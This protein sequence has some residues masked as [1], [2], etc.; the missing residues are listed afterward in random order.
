[1]PDSIKKA[2]VGSGGAIILAATLV[3]SGI[4]G[5]NAVDT[6]GSSLSPA[7][8]QALKAAGDTL[9]IQALSWW[10]SCSNPTNLPSSRVDTL[11]TAQAAGLDIGGYILLDNHSTGA[12]A[13][14]RAYNGIPTDLWNSLQFAAIDFEIPGDCWNASTRI[15]ETTICDAL[16]ELSRLGAPRLLYTSYGEWGSHLDPS[17]PLGCPNT[18]LWLASWNGDPNVDFDNHPFGGWQASDVVIKQY[19]GNTSVDG[20]YVDNDSMSLTPFPWLTPPPVV[21]YTQWGNCDSVHGDVWNI[22]IQRWVFPGSLLFDPN[23]NTF[24]SSPNC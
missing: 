18:Y 23:T 11:R 13:V 4:F 15:P 5:G 3:L 24:A 7:Q 19:T 2:I 10:P 21:Q 8:A 12:E 6:A 14:D 22:E 20:F 9:V 17:N 1:M 16:D